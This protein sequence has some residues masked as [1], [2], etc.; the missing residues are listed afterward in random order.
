M[1]VA[2]FAGRRTA[3]NGH[4]HSRHHFSA[5]RIVRPRRAGQC[6]AEQDRKSHQVLGHFP[7]GLHCADR[8]A[9]A[10]AHRTVERCRWIS[11]PSCHIAVLLDFPG[12]GNCLCLHNEKLQLAIRHFTGGVRKAVGEAGPDG[13]LASGHVKAKEPVGCSTQHGGD[14]YQR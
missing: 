2:L 1:H 13:C 6:R 3:A 9:S 11:N 7:S 8:S 14:L 4:M 5:S 10:M 12:P